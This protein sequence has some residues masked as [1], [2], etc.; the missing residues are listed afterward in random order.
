[1]LF[2]SSDKE[3]LFEAWLIDGIS[4][5]EGEKHK[6]L[7]VDEAKSLIK[8]L[9]EK[10]DY[11][12]AKKLAESLRNKVSIS[13]KE[14]LRS[15][16]ISFPVYLSIVQMAFEKATSLGSVIKDH[17]AKDLTQIIDSLQK[18]KISAEKRELV[19]GTF[20]K[21]KEQLPAKSSYKREEYT[22]SSTLGTDDIS[23]KIARLC[24]TEFLKKVRTEL[25]KVPEVL[26]RYLVGIGAKET[27]DKDE[28]LNIQLNPQLFEI[29][30]K[31]NDKGKLQISL[32]FTNF[33]SSFDM[34][35]A[36]FRALEDELRKDFGNEAV[37]ELFEVHE[38]FFSKEGPFFEIELFSATIE[39][40]DEKLFLNNVEVVSYPPHKNHDYDKFK[41]TLLKEYDLNVTQL[42]KDL[43]ELLQANQY[44]KIVEITQKL[45]NMKTRRILA[46]FSLE[47]IAKL[48]RRKTQVISL[49]APEILIL[50]W[51]AKRPK[52]FES[53]LGVEKQ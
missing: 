8:E 47:V 27:V 3:A 41:A 15:Y 17:I 38:G 26:D 12:L 7:E 36:E 23:D 31:P 16:R 32:S 9:V 28:I 20:E 30:L 35:E 24:Q 10:E 13:D 5:K 2:V 46:D 37:H 25:S 53:F 45:S 49:R 4:L 29:H 51:E 21:W 33:L 14:I 43:E 40:R 39:L 42:K 50:M 6:V 34:S 44:D 11:N 22:L 18:R 19:K 48:L 52:R 1:M